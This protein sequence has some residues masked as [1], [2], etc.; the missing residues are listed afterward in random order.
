MRPTPGVWGVESVALYLG[1]KDTRRLAGL[2]LSSCS[3]GFSLFKSIVFCSSQYVPPSIASHWSG[4]SM[5]RK[6]RLARAKRKL[7]L[8]G[9][10]SRKTI[11]D[12]CAQR[13]RGE[14]IEKTEEEERSQS[15]GLE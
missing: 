7:C 1:G 8:C 3:G 15:F 5:F 14:A 13:I 10:P 4:D 9:K 11:G 6:R 2:P 12:A